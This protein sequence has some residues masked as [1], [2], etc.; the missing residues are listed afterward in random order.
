MM[1]VAYRNLMLGRRGLA[2][3]CFAIAGGFSLSLMMLVENYLL[4]PIM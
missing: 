3:R 4:H 2:R 1:R